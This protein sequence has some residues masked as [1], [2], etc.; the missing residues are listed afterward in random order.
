MREE[1]LD[2]HIEQDY[3]TPVVV[4]VLAISSI[5]ANSLVGLALICMFFLFPYLKEDMSRM[6]EEYMALIYYSLCSFM[7]ILQILGFIGVLKMLNGKRS[8]FTLYA[9]GT[10]IW[11]L[12][13]FAGYQQW[14]NILFAMVSIGFIVSFGL[15]LKSMRKS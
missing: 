9:I 5:V 7:L 13:L 3:E 10:G 12:L 11:V 14:I 15:Q 2:G 1:V 4:K 8:G 6:G